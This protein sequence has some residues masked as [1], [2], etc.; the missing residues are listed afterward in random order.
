[1]ETATK[2]PFTTADT[3]E[4][5]TAPVFRWNGEVLVLEIEA[6]LDGG[7]RLVGVAQLGAEGFDAGA[8]PLIILAVTRTADAAGELFGL[9]VYVEGDTGTTYYR[10]QSA[11]WEAITAEVFFH[12][13]MGQADGPENLPRNRRRTA[14]PIPPPLRGMDELTHTPGAKTFWA[15]PGE[16]ASPPLG[17]HPAEPRRRRVARAS[18]LR[19]HRR[20]GW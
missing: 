4:A 16:R 20:I 1:M 3:G 19:Q 5:I 12:W 9:G 6:R 10:T 14:R 17:Q 13:N 11:H 18:Q 7:D 8:W 2:T 15:P